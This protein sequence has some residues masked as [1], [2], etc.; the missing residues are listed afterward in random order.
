MRQQK[1]LGTRKPGA[2]CPLKHVKES[3]LLLD[4]LQATGFL[5]KVPTESMRVDFEVINCSAGENEV[6]R[7]GSDLLGP[8]P[9]PDQI[10]H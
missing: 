3:D 5:N 8:L 7:A 10:C 4:T 1:W 6:L 2:F 9:D